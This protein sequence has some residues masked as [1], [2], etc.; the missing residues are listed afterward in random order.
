MVKIPE[1]HTPS[2]ISLG[3]NTPDSLNAVGSKMQNPYADAIDTLGFGLRIAGR[4]LD[5]NQRNKEAELKAAEAARK[6]VLSSQLKEYQAVLSMAMSDYKA[7]HDGEKI[8]PNSI[9]QLGNRTIEQAFDP[10]QAKILGLREALP[11]ELREKAMGIMFDTTRMNYDGVVKNNVSLD[12]KWTVERNKQSADAFVNDMGTGV[13]PL[14]QSSVAANALLI[15]YREAN[16]PDEVAAMQ[17]NT[18]VRSGVKNWMLNNVDNLSDMKGVLTGD[19]KFTDALTGKPYTFKDMV[20][21]KDYQA[22]KKAY[23][24]SLEIQLAETSVGIKGF[25]VRQAL[26]G[27]GLYDTEA[28][29]NAANARVREKQKALEIQRQQVMDDEARRGFSTAMLRDGGNTPY[30]LL[31]LNARSTAQERFDLQEENVDRWNKELKDAGF[32]SFQRKSDLKDALFNV[33]KQK[34]NA[35][36]FITTEVWSSAPFDYRR[37]TESKGYEQAGGSQKY[38]LE[39]MQLK[40]QYDAIK[41]AMPAG[42]DVEDMIDKAV[43]SYDTK[44]FYGK[45]YIQPD[46]RRELATSLRN[47]AP[48][49]REVQDAVNQAVTKYYNQHALSDPEQK[50]DVDRIVSVISNKTVNKK[51]KETQDDVWMKV[52]DELQDDYDS[53]ILDRMMPYIISGKIVKAVGVANAFK[54]R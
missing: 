18:L 23:Q 16:V 1:T 14:A 44:S 28:E 37:I 26:V 39:E 45:D 11:Q 5:Q 17:V 34:G 29:L 53:D 42:I 43:K 33:E 30:D 12:A 2:S 21:D 25:D 9:I 4:T 8:D 38:I 36:I 22:A 46:V 19:M 41:D 52:R 49:K 13:I 40:A 27:G 20:D 50:S 35:E 7:K 6:E 54:R 3:R 10:K 24:S 32:F 47:V 31:V 51:P 15:A 48:T